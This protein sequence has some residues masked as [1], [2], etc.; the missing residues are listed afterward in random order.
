MGRSRGG[1][2]P[3]IVVVGVGLE[4]VGEV[5][6][7]LLSRVRLRVQAHRVELSRAVNLW[8][9]SM[10]SRARSVRVGFP[11]CLCDERLE[12][13]TADRVV[14]SRSFADV[15]ESSRSPG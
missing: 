1:R 8:K 5:L 2:R 11:R 6:E 12:G 9:L 4:V 7:V 13:R 15:V 3:T 14:F 10:S